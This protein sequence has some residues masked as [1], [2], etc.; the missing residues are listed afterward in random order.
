MGRLTPLA[1]R[2]QWAW[3]G[4]RRQRRR[5]WPKGTSNRIGKIARPGV[6]LSAAMR[7]A[8]AASSMPAS[9]SGRGRQHAATP[10]DHRRKPP[11]LAAPQTPED[12]ARPRGR[13]ANARCWN[14][15]RHRAEPCT[16]CP[17]APSVGA[18]RPRLAEDLLVTRS[19]FRKSG[20]DWTL[21]SVEACR[22]RPAPITARQD[23][24]IRARPKLGGRPR[25]ADSRRD[26]GWWLLVG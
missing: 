9:F 11:V 3:S 18:A 5:L 6:S 24:A 4:D 8:G 17:E 15:S 25:R 10:V 22:G 26:K 14:G 7:A 16:L 19:T 13:R 20:P 21:T 1:G 2:A 12:P 23:P